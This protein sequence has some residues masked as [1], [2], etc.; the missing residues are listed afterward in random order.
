MSKTLKDEVLRKDKKP[1]ADV[2][3]HPSHDENHGNGGKDT[4]G[5]K[6]K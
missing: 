6:E 1:P 3:H 5:R 4:A 2:N